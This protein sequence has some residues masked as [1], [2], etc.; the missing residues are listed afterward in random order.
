[1]LKSLAQIWSVVLVES[2]KKII[3]VLGPTATGKSQ[4]ALDLALELD[5]E[6]INADSVQVYE[7]L[8][9]GAASPSFDDKAKVPHHLYGFYSLFKE[10][11]ASDFLKDALSVLD[12]CQKLPMIVGGSGFYIQALE[13][14][15]YAPVNIP[16]EVKE[17]VQRLHEEGG[18]K[19]LKTLLSRLDPISAQKIHES[20][21]YRLLR[22]TQASMALKKPWSEVREAFSKNS[23]DPLEAFKKIKLGL[24]LEREEL[25]ALV[26]RRVENMLKN[27]LINEV[28]ELLIRYNLDINNPPKPL[29]SV[30]Y[31]ETL[32]FLQ[33]K[34][35]KEE[36]KEQIIQSTMALAKRQ[37]TWFQRDKEISWFHGLKQLAEAKAFVIDELHAIKK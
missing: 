22:A 29:L 17:A 15:M 23:K 1:V 3:F 9:I 19:A 11:N 33:N 31:K 37:R 34:I 24:W 5:G 21:T 6:L 30:G 18:N 36:L 16:E 25:K 32:L 10:Y 7:G 8:L 27:G 13:K 14:G 12:K 20:D 2:I 4:F 28:S 35:S 26:V